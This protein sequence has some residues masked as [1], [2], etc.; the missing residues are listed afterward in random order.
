MD[1]GKS[2]CGFEEMGNER[3]KKGSGE[4]WDS[5]NEGIE[6]GTRGERERG[7]GCVRGC[8]DSFY[9][10]NVLIGCIGG[11]VRG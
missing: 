3:V 6:G 7:R 4:R 9:F 5:G 1:G 8:I 10:E 11:C 2:G